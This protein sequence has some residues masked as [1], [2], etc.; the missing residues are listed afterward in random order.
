MTSLNKKK[1]RNRPKWVRFF[2]KGSRKLV[3]LVAPPS[4][5]RLLTQDSPSGVAEDAGHLTYETQR[6]EKIFSLEEGPYNHFKFI[7][8]MFSLS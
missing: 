8:E 2:E 1:H 4:K 6:W 3:V 5:W 7:Q